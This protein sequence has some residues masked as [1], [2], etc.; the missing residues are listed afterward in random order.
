[1]SIIP[2]KEKRMNSVGVGR[3]WMR[4]KLPGA[5]EQP[6]RIVSGNGYGANTIASSA[7]VAQPGLEF[8]LPVNR[9]HGT[10]PENRMHHEM[11]LNRMHFTVPEDE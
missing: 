11:P 6:W 2:A 1:M 3:P 5:K 8:T 9:M 10:L 7:G 4:T